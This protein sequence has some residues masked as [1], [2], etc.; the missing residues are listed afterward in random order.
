MNQI[1]YR[2]RFME[3]VKKTKTCWLWI[4]GKTSKGYGEFYPIPNRVSDLHPPVYAHRFSYELFTG[5]IPSGFEIS[6]SCNN[7]SCVN[8]AHLTAA[9]HRENMAA[10]SSDGLFPSHPFR[11][12]SREQVH[13]IRKLAGMVTQRELAARYGATQGVI[14]LAT[15]GATYKRP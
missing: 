1:K 10:A 14:S 4:A 15:S 13:T 6:H 8:P 3:M 2:K 9:T 5:P 11:K 7:P 12:L